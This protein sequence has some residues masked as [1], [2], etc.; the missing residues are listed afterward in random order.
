MLGHSDIQTT[1]IYARHVP[2]VED[3]ARLSALLAKSM[4]DA[5]LGARTEPQ[6]TDESEAEEVGIGALEPDLGCRRRDSNPRHADYDSAAL[7]S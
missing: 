4:K 2:R 7:T 5:A 6:G 1:M 3:A